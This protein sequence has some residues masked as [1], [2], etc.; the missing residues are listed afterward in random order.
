MYPSS[1]SPIWIRKTRRVKAGEIAN[2]N[3]L[4][5]RNERSGGPPFVKFDWKYTG[6]TLESCTRNQTSPLQ[7]WESNTVSPLSTNVLFYLAHDR[8]ILLKVEK[9]GYASL[10]FAQ[11]LNFAPLKCCQRKRK[12]EFRIIKNVAL[13]HWKWIKKGDMF[14]LRSRKIWILRGKVLPTKKKKVQDY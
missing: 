11:D 9:G 1:T 8:F 2:R 13:F 6:N 10:T 12:K 14:N 5:G 7:A 4:R 3:V